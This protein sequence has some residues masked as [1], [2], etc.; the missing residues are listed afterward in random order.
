MP[1]IKGCIYGLHV[2]GVVVFVFGFQ[3][4]KFLLYVLTTSVLRPTTCS[5][6]SK[7]FQIELRELGYLN[8]EPWTMGIGNVEKSAVLLYYYYSTR[9]LNGVL[10]SN[11]VQHTH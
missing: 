6:C 11:I 10:V 1:C 8:S 4:Q 2:R 3:L 9:I 7:G 5:V